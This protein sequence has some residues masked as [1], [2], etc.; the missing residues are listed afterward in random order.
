MDHQA[1]HEQLFAFYDGELAGE[2][3]RAVEDHLLECGECRS[4]LAQWERVAG[5]LFQAPA[6]SP[7][8]AFIERVMYRIAM[9]HRKPLYWPRWMVE[10]R[11]LTPAIG[12][13]A[14]VFVIARGPLQQ[15]VSI[16]NL[17]LSN[18]REPVALQQVLREES[19]SA[20]DVLGL[21]MEE[22]S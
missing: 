13:A 12:L 14:M 19:P 10:R 3:R 5:M 7:S 6:V 16:E 4:L 17:L 15:T 20:D 9:P 11:W 8:E 21:L 1:V 2:P 18:G 22:I